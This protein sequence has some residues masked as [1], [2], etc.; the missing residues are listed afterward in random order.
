[1]RE[2]GLGP[3]EFHPSDREEDG[4]TP[5]VHEVPDALARHWIESGVCKSAQ[6]LTAVGRAP[7]AAMR[8]PAEARTR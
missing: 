6:G 1:M 7:E 5:K 2:H 3:F 4:V 8:R